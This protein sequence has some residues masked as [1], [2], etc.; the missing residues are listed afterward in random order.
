M[1]VTKT[2]TDVKLQ[3]RLESETTKNGKVV[4]KNLNLHKIN[5]SA[6]KGQLFAAGEALAEL[7]TLALSGIRTID[8]SKLSSG[9]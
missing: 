4:T 5:P 8:T 1:A 6:T 2:L 7:Q 3:L 9:E